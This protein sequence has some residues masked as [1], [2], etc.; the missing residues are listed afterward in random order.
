MKKMIRKQ[1]PKP[2]EH[3]IKDLLETETSLQKLTFNITYCPGFQ[4]IKNILQE[5]HLS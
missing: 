5:L 3:S 1:I 2:R 4:N